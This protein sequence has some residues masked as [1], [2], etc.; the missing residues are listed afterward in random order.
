MKMQYKLYSN[1]LLTTFIALLL[2]AT[3]VMSYA[4]GVSANQPETRLEPVHQAV[5]N[6]NESNLSELVTLKGIGEHKAQAIINYR[7]QVGSF[8]SLSELSAVRGVG[9]KI[10]ADN[11]PRLTL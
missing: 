10:I 7:Q 11:K 5:V 9:D 1:A 2:S 3:S 6:I 8:K 4:N